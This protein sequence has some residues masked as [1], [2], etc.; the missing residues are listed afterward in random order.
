LLNQ[1]VNWENIPVCSQC[2]Y[3][4]LWVTCL[5]VCIISYEYLLCNTGTSRSLFVYYVLN[6]SNISYHSFSLSPPDFF[7]GFPPMGLT[8]AWKVPTCLLAATYSSII[9]VLDS[10]NSYVNTCQFYHIICSAHLSSSYL[11][12]ILIG[13][14]TKFIYLTIIAG[15]TYSTICCFKL[16]GF[17]WD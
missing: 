9:I 2:L 13:K 14:Q 16:S 10:R 17:W 5:I 6:M 12:G 1:R 3:I 11:F 8:M 4:V 7:N 15:Q